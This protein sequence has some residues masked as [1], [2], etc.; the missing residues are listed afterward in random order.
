VSAQRYSS[1]MNIMRI[2]VAL[3]PLLLSGT[4]AAQTY[5]C[6]SANGKVTYSSTKCSELG[7]KDAGEVPDRINV[8][9]AYRPPKAAEP[10][11]SPAPAPAPSAAPA[12]AP[13]APG[14]D[15]PAAADPGKPDRRCFTVRT[16]T[17]TATRCNDKPDE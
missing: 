6:T 9:P 1:S 13:K 17:G 5:K 12:A 15:T 7:L 14:A 2:V 11:Q 16:P 4:A 3:A 10:R 8:N